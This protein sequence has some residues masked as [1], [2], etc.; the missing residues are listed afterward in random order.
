MTT[1]NN[2]TRGYLAGYGALLQRP[3]PAG[4]NSNCH[5]QFRRWCNMLDRPKST[6]PQCITHLCGLADQNRVLWNHHDLRQRSLRWRIPAFLGKLFQICMRHVFGFFLVN[7]ALPSLCASE[8][9]QDITFFSL[10][11]I[12]L[13]H[14][15]IHKT[16]TTAAVNHRICPALHTNKRGVPCSKTSRCQNPRCLPISI[17]PTH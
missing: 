8:N 13:T 4:R 17:P 15:I 1:S 3:M 7:R 2:R 12:N 5:K 16:E 14:R 11:L 6:M 9:R 10:T